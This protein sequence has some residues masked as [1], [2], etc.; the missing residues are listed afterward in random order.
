MFH[1]PV[2]I[3][4]PQ[5]DSRVFQPA[6]STA[7]EEVGTG[8]YLPTRRWSSASVCYVPWDPWR[9]VLFKVQSISMG[10]KQSSLAAAVTFLEALSQRVAAGGSFS[11][12]RAGPAGLSHPPSCRGASDPSWPFPLTPRNGHGCPSALPAVSGGKREIKDCIIQAQIKIFTGRNLV[13]SLR[14]EWIM[15]L[16]T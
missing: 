3:I 16:N 5:N 12:G 14:R 15:Y 7:K 4:V 1:I 8:S 9:K 13:E 11:C 2:L 6:E 10:N